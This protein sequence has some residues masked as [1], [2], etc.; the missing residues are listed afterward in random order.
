L[1]NRLKKDDQISNFINGLGQKTLAGTI[2]EI[3][4]FLLNEIK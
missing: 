2:K 4:N 1:D 3:N